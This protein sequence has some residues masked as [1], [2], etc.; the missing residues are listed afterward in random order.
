MSINDSIKDKKIA[1]FKED[2]FK[3]EDKIDKYKRLKQ[4]LYEDALEEEEHARK[5]VFLQQAIQE[6]WFK[7]N[8]KDYED[9]IDES[10]LIL[11]TF[12][13]NNADIYEMCEEAINCIINDTEDEKYNLSY[14]LNHI[15]ESD[16]KEEIGN[17]EKNTTNGNY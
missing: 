14:C 8:M 3:C 16:D 13:L 11:D 12:Q 17:G 10:M 2:I 15:Y 1:K 9:I 5:V 4:K 7:R 6:D